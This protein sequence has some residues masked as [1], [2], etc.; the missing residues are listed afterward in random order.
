LQSLAWI[1]RLTPAFCALTF[2]I[3]FAQSPAIPGTPA[4]RTLS[5]FLDAFNSAD[6]AKLD[7]YI[8]TYDSSET[9]DDLAGFHA[10][11]GNFTLLSIVDSTPSFISFRLKQASDGKEVFGTFSL[12]STNPPKVKSWTVRLMRPGQTLDTTPV[13]A[14]ARKRVIDSI[15]TKL[16][17]FYIYPDVAKNMIASLNQHEQHGDYDRYTSGTEFAAALH[18]DLLAV[19]SDHHIF[20]DY[21]PFNPPPGAKPEDDKPHPPSPEDTARFRKQLEHDNCAFTKVE[22]LPR[23]IGYVKFNEF[24]PPDLC[25]ATVVAALGFLAHTD[26]VIVDLRENHG[27]DPAMVQF[28]ASY[29]F[30]TPTH[31]N[32]LY[33]RHDDVIHQYWTQGFVPGP[34]ITAPLYVL[35]SGQTFS[36]AEEFTYDM[37]TQKRAIIVGE[38][39][40]GGAHPVDG[41]P[42]GDHFTIGVP[43]ERPINP[44]TKKDWE[45]T[46]ITPDVQVPAADALTTAQ[47]LAE[48]KLSQVSPGNP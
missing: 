4:G 29:F 44:I 34:R 3:A 38:T 10:E 24:A 19:S 7:A 46:G 47:K 17:E 1:K 41:M 26:A 25:G 18:D 11:T 27:G 42:A 2:S 6:H 16:T 9:V 40:G 36:G 35:T 43:L 28:I 21:D 33:N 15:S 20:V 30:D 12:A 13:D 22:I 23:N 8:H 31:I 48:K 5:A 45:G 32:D 37:Q 39:T 14:A